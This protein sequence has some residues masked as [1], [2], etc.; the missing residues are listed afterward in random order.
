VT[1]RYRPGKSA[2]SVYLAGSFNDWK[3]AAQKMDGPDQE[4]RFTT[5]LKLK[6]GT[7]E[8]EFVLNGQ[9]SETNPDNV[10]LTGPHQK[11]VLRIGVRP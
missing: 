11:R 6:S 1:F 7:Y 4:G 3:P 8:Y 9:T 2:K 5:R 10:S